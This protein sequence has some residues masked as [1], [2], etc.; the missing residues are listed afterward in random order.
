[1]ERVRRTLQVEMGGQ[2]SDASRGNGPQRDAHNPAV[3]WEHFVG[4][5]RG[6]D[7][8]VADRSEARAS[9]SGTHQGRRG[10]GS[11]SDG[12]SGAGG[13]GFGGDQQQ[14]GGNRR[15][16]GHISEPAARAS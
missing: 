2:S 8:R 11:G 1:M 5:G 4:T 6:G 7:T 3:D 14:R 16:M 13:S 12:T 9:V 15:S 10:R